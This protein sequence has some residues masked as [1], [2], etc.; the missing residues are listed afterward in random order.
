MTVIEELRA[1][2]ELLAQPGV[3]CQRPPQAPGR[4]CMFIYRPTEDE[5]EEVRLSP[6]AVDAVEVVADT[7]AIG[8]WNDS[9]ALA[10]V[11][12]LLDRTI[13]RLETTA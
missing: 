6:E 11:L 3:W 13:A 8:D 7:D 4:A 12:A 9:H 5:D 1:R 10:E 2:R